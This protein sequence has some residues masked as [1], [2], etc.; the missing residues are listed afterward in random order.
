MIDN[1]RIPKLNEVIYNITELGQ[2]NITEREEDNQ[3]TRRIL[4]PIEI[5]RFLIANKGI[6]KIRMN[7][8]NTLHT[9]VSMLWQKMRIA[10][11]GNKRVIRGK[12]QIFLDP[13]VQNIMR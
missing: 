5:Y 1:T 13:I 2:L 10:G 11:R 4:L 6:K 8:H 3:P 12:E 9:N 7:F